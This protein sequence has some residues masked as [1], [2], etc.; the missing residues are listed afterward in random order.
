MTSWTVRDEALLQRAAATGTKPEP[1]IT[2]GEALAIFHGMFVEEYK[3]AEAA[4]LRAESLQFWLF[5]T[6]GWCVLAFGAFGWA[7]AR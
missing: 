3:R 7:V 5:I 6:A 2:E 4:T 1:D